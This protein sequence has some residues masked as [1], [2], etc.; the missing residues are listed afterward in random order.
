MSVK[1]PTRTHKI[2]F[3][4]PSEQK[5]LAIKAIEPVKDLKV[6][7]VKKADET[8]RRDSMPTTPNDEGVLFSTEERAIS[9]TRRASTQIDKRK[10]VKSLRQI[11]RRL[12]LDLVHTEQPRRSKV[13]T[14]KQ[15]DGK[16]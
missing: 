5:H 9:P 2:R 11:K 13:V 7:S 14:S 8:E 12:F 16:E 4:P 6:C 10:T 3:D 15:K 1:I